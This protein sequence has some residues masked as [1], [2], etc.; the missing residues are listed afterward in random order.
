MFKTYLK[1]TLIYVIDHFAVESKR[2]F[3]LSLTLIIIGSTLALIIGAIFLLIGTFAF[4]YYNADTFWGGYT[5]EGASVKP[6]HIINKR[7]GYPWYRPLWLFYYQ[8]DQ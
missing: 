7:N 6:I 3:N 1:E 2:H 8:H 5:G 4:G